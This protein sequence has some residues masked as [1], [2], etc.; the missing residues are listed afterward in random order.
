[1]IIFSAIAQFFDSFVDNVPAGIAF[2]VAFVTAATAIVL[3][4]T[5]VSGSNEKLKYEFITIIAHKYRTPLTYI[6]W[7]TGELMS[8]EQ[9]SYKKELLT[10]MQESN[11]KLIQLT[12]SLVELTDSKS[13]SGSTYNLERMSLSD[14]A[15]N[16]GKQYKDA[17]HKKNLFFSVQRP[18][19]DI[20]V[21]IDRSRMEF[22]V[23]TLL[24]NAIAYT[25]TGKNVEMSV[26][27]TKHKAM[28][29]VADGGI[30]IDPV[31][32]PHI[33]TKFFRAANARTADTEGFGVALY[34]AKMIT[35]RHKGKL[36]IESEGLNKGTRC[37]VVLK[38]V[39]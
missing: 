1:M 25:P 22:V 35:L 38:R 28:I 19:E 33:T 16:I 29:T 21:K 2:L 15:H 17:F 39:P 11:E 36:I 37:T 31:D 8:S 26:N 24:E 5:K 6:K 7:S 12:G 30:G 20:M 13:T 3:K 18:S 4:F 34:L 27:A 32:M 10:N 23:Q 9:D 14:F